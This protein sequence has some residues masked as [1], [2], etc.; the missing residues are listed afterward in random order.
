MLGSIFPCQAGQFTCSC[1]GL[2]RTYLE[3]AAHHILST[4]CLG[5]NSRCSGSKSPILFVTV[6]RT[7][8]MK[9][10]ATGCLRFL[11]GRV[12]SSMSERGGSWRAQLWR[13]RMG[14]AGI[15]HSLNPIPFRLDAMTRIA[16]SRRCKGKG[17]D[18]VVPV[19]GVSTSFASTSLAEYDSL[20][21]R[22]RLLRGIKYRLM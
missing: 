5:R 22:N 14:R 11:A 10:R 4:T 19:W 15:V 9:E 18:G 2:A 12:L 16:I 20:K 6:S 3:S 1:E 7:I 13:W 21:S 8:S 17:K